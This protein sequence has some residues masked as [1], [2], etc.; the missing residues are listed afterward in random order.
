[1]RHS[2]VLAL[3]VAGALAVAAG[4]L[5]LWP[6]GTPVSVAALE[7]DAQRGAYLARA[8]GCIACHSDPGSGRPALTGGA[9]IET[10]FGRFVPPN[11][12]PHDTAGIGAWSIEDFARAVRQGIAPDGAPY[13]PAF[14]YPFYGD[15]S[16]QDVVDMWA[17]FQT[18]PP[19]D[20]VAQ[21]HEVGFPLNLR[22]G[23]KLWRAAYASKSVMQP[24]PSRD[25]AWNRGRW[26]VNGL[27]HCGACHTDRNL[28]GGRR[29]DRFL[30]GSDDLPEGGKAPAITPDALRRA[31]WEANAL[32]FALKSGV[33][34][35]GD[36][37]GGGMGEVVQHGTA[38]LTAEDQTAIAVYLLDRDGADE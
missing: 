7:G 11:I 28:V 3:A 26:L 20:M 21:G 27:A 14:P 8:G 2:V 16:D 29:P 6:I 19:Q 32:A 9:A 15:L 37:F 17:A 31:G 18:V 12:T 1:M 24:D 34:P 30:M 23:L 38:W 33:K 13:Y 5:A 10:G 36:T 4:A 25:A 35:D 22:F